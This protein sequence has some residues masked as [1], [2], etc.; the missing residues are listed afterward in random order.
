MIT[1]LAQIL[2]AR[3]LFLT[4]SL[5]E[6]HKRSDLVLEHDLRKPDPWLWS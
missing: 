1:Y 6:C 5:S 2:T 3:Q 4:L